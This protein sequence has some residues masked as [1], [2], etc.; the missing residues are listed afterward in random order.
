MRS[1]GYEIVIGKQM[2]KSKAEIAVV[3]GGPSGLI[4]ALALGVAGVEAILFAPPMASPDRRTTALLDGSVQA[5]KRLAVWDSLSSHTAPLEKLRL[6]DGTNRLVRA[7]EVLFS[8]GELGLD[9]FG[10]NIENESLRSVLRA[11]VGRMPT[12]SVVEQAVAKV[13][14]ADD[15]VLLAHDGG[16]VA[17][18]LVIA[19][20]GRRS[21]C[22]EAAGI[23]TSRREFPQVALTMNLRHSRPHEN[24]STEF[25]TETGPFTL[26][27]LPGQRSSL[28]CVVDPQQ[29]EE[30]S[31]LDD[32]T[33]GRDIERRA[34]S[35]L[36]RMEI[37][38]ARG[39]FPLAIETADRLA[40][41]RIALVGEAGH[42]LPPI[43]AQG[44]NLGIRD[45]VT[46]AELAVV[47]L[48]DGKDAGVDE[49][50]S[51]YEKTRKADVGSRALAV[52]L[53]NRSL[54]SGFLPAHV[55]R[56]V[57]LEAASRIGPLRRA[58]MRQGLGPQ[59][60]LQAEKR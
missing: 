55:A 41:R 31:A 22:R 54:L 33:L 56:A 1:P 40:A 29:A 11:A 28:V 49:V 10:H 34:H 14:V 26:V 58:V 24:T 53:F 38:G 46:I 4:A 8:C 30:L 27:P 25:H 60:V 21:L 9:A 51:A 2:T 59:S 16:E 17:V 52:D 36:G 37:D 44:L 43:G 23:G 19:A 12:I 42:L 6:V 20:D 48:R 18:S 47:A 5:L 7:P 45:A 35:I 39:R 50:L 13:S 57:G 3:G 15:A 32:A